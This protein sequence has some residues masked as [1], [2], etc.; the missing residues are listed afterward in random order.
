MI[1][2]SVSKVAMMKSTRATFCLL[3]AV[4]CGNIVDGLIPN[5]K[6]IVVSFDAFKPEYLEMGLTPFM[7]IFYKSGI[8]ATQMNSS[9]PTKTF[10]NHFCIATGLNY[11]YF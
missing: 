1:A 8:R 9:F 10:V 2:E 5:R 7:D 11:N 3:F 4:F 6:L